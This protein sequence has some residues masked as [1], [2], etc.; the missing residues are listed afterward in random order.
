MRISRLWKR[1]WILPALLLAGALAAAGCSRTK[2]DAQLAGEVQNKISASLPNQPITVTA[3]EGVVTLSGAVN[4]ETDRRA[5]A[6]EAAQVEGVKV[7][8]NDLQVTPAAASI[9]EAPAASLPQ[10]APAVPRASPYRA[11]PHRAEVARSQPPSSPLPE[12]IPPAPAAAAPVPVRA[13]VEH[14]TI[15]EGTLL[16]VRMV[17]GIDS[18]R[19]RLGDT[20]LATLEAPLLVGDRVVAPVGTQVEGRVT[21]LKSAGHFSGRSELA[22][23][24]VR[25]DMGHGSYPLETSAWTSQGDSRG[26]RTAATIGGGAALGAIIGAIAG[27]GK[28]AA[29][30][31]VAGAGAG[32]GV[33]AAT[34]GKQLKVN[35]EAVLDFR[36]QAPVTVVPSRAL[37]RERPRLEQQEE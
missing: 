3:Q 18:E 35:P 32:T 29:I 17:D 14:V 11:K 21:D 6:Q 30:G 28:G 8:V 9:P 5:A 26:K 19:N 20:F 24:L 36:L 33:Q 15:P 2:T 37:E 7:V 1:T 16:S 23:E 34:K 12:P 4:N 27:G 25:L 10:S 13:A 31:T 22:L